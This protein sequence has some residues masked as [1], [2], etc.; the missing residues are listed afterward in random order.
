MKIPWSIPNIQDK[1]I[2]SIN[3]VLDSGWLSMGK[4]VKKFEEKVASYLKIKYSISVNNGTSAL[5]LA[6]KCLDLNTKDE[7]IIPALTYIATGNVVLYNNCI[8]VFVDIDNTLNIDTTLI[9]EKITK[10][11]K[12]I[13]NID[14]GGNPTNYK[15][16]L[17]ISDENSLPLIVDGAQSFGSEYQNKKC[18]THGL[19]N[20]TSFHAA[21]IIT[22]VEGGMIFTNDKKINDKANI[23]RNQGETSKYIHSYLGNNYRMTDLAASIGNS[24]MDR[25]ETTLEER[26]NKAKYYK[27][28]LKNVD[29]PEEL[30]NT[31]NCH[32]FFLILVKNRNKL[33]KCLNKNGIETRITYP[34]PINEQTIFKKY[35]KQ[36]YISA[37][38]FSKKVI[39]LPIHHK[40]TI[41]EQDY[42][43]KK[44]NNFDR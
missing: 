18:C 33:N 1:E 14:L 41:D 24:Q 28:N 23:L 43:I 3:R 25:F 26:I 32:F 11:T 30:Q 6:L 34:L 36:D 20:T 9:E 44:I 37:K 4:E 16:L 19:I 10:K 21:K 38:K 17:K 40:L 13:I 2:E 29:Y 7:I 15:N 12:A 8:P 35:S 22:T 42:I 27:Q 39:S 31:K 5:D